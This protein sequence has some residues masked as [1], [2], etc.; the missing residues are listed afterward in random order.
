MAAN[1]KAVIDMGQFVKA[2]T[3]DFL[4]FMD[5]SERPVFLVEA[6]CEAKDRFGCVLAE[7]FDQPDIR[8][9]AII[10]GLQDFHD[11][12]LKYNK[13]LISIAFLPQAAARE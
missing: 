5:P 2:K 4:F 10:P 12:I 7:D 11:Q 1:F 6:R 8:N 13:L 3:P 9:N